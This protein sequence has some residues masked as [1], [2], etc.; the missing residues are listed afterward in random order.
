MM[1]LKSS[2][3]TAAV[4]AFLFAA[5]PFAGAQS[6]CGD[7]LS[8]RLIAGQ[9]TDSGSVTVGNDGEFLYVVYNTKDGWVLAETH[10]DVELSLAE[11]PQTG[12]GNPKV[13]HFAYSFTHNGATTYVYAIP[14]S[15]LGLEAGDTLFVAAHAVVNLQNAGGQVVRRETGWG[16]GPGFPGKNWAM[17]LNFTVQD[18]E[19]EEE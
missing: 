9:H 11:I 15:S 14:L 19:E 17:Y 2:L 8:V 16:E 1:T 10:V 12:S 3:A 13:G 4:A 5:A 18:C 7:P 6:I